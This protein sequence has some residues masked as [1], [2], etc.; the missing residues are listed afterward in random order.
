MDA[1]VLP[2]MKWPKQLPPLTPEQE[3]ISDDFMQVWHQVL[4]ARYGMFEEFNHGFPIR[5]APAFPGC[6]TLEIGPGL[7][8]HVAHEDR[9][10]QSYHC[11]E[12]RESM[13][14]I[15]KQRFPDV[16]VIVGDCQKRLPYP[17]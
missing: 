15:I 11:V 16:N 7:G 12:L 9:A 8:G 13:A 17:D 5:R 1:P 3:A 10:E 14:Q 4:P 6:R 2:R